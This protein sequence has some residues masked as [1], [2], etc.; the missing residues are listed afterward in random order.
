MSEESNL[1]TPLY[2]HPP[3]LEWN[4]SSASLREGVVSTCQ[5]ASNSTLFKYFKLGDKNTVTNVWSGIQQAW[6]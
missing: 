5:A 1:F 6:I 2:R 3:P 4:Y